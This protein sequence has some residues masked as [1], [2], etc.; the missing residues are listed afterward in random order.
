MRDG[1]ELLAVDRCSTLN[2]DP[3]SRAPPEPGDNIP[4]TE[5]PLCDREGRLFP[6]LNELGIPNPALL[7]GDNAAK[8]FI[9]TTDDAE[10]DRNEDERG[11]I[12]TLWSDEGRVLELDRTSGRIGLVGLLEFV[13][14]DPSDAAELGGSS[15]EVMADS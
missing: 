10:A 5:G 9:T 12:T 7:L 11:G 3:A 1:S 14:S 13:D 8:L 6:L 4:W 15:G 2:L